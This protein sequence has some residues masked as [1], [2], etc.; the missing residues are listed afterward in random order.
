MEQWYESWNVG[1]TEESN[2]RNGG[3]VQREET[4]EMQVNVHN[5]V[6]V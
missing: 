4:C 1:F 2:M 5:K 3:L 6:Q